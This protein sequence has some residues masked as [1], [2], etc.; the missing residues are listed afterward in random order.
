VPDQGDAHAAAQLSAEAVPVL[1]CQVPTLASRWATIGYHI[2]IAADLV[3]LELE[4]VAAAYGN[5]LP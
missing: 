4:K 1:K 5:L 3:V 2:V